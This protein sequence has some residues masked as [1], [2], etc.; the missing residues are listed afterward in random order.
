[1][2]PRE[3][4]KIVASVR[5][6]A[7]NGSDEMDGSRSAFLANTASH[8]QREQVER[9][10]AALAKSQPVATAASIAARRAASGMGG[11][12]LVVPS[13]FPVLQHSLESLDCLPQPDDTLSVKAEGGLI[14]A[15]KAETVR[16]QAAKRKAAA[17][18]AAGAG[19]SGAGAGA[20][21]KAKLKTPQFTG[22][23]QAVLAAAAGRGDRRELDTLEANALLLT[24]ARQEW[25]DAGEEEKKAR[26]EEHD[27]WLKQVAKHKAAKKAEKEAKKAEKA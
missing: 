20:A 10:R 7:K 4:A 18:A 17:A 14:Y 26:R 24:Q 13:F 22:A 1:M 6:G 5:L 2:D 27:E 15:I 16:A 21:E 8:K 25:E 3:A 11:E 23:F 12:I 19:G 9:H